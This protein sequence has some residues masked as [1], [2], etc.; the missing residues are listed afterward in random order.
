MRRLP[1]SRPRRLVAAGLLVLAAALLLGRRP[2]LAWRVELVWR[3]ARGDLAFLSWKELPGCL[4]PERIPSRKRPRVL[5]YL[6]WN[7]RPAADGAPLC[8]VLW[9][10]AVGDFWGRRH[11]GLLFAGLLREQLEE[12]I[13]DRPPV[14]VQAGD[15]VL[16]VGGHLGS[17]TR[18]ALRQGAR[19]V[20]AFEPEP[21]NRACFQRTFQQE[22]AA[23]RVV[24]VEAA[25]W[26][27]PGE[28]QFHVL[29]ENSAGGSS[30]RHSS[31]SVVTVPAVTIDDTVGRLALD[32]V[33]F[34]KLDIEGAERHALRGAARTLA[35]FGPRVVACTYPLDDDP[36][37][38]P[39]VMLQARPSYRKFHTASQAY[40]Y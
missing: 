20:V 13:Y 30:V 37:A 11:D 10:T 2:K 35:R 22:I 40:L 1:N 33:D 26:S 29:N 18:L 12:R 4:A 16:D 14:A 6:R 27:E 38:V 3:K 32:R 19:L 25:A 28:L 7:V 36:V 9:S 34:I 23:H 31:G 24:L 39:Q 5:S 8:P 21:V 17:F 15:V